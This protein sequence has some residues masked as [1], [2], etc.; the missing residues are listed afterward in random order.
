MSTIKRDIHI[1]SG[2]WVR[3]LDSRIK[4]QTGEY[5]VI[6]RT[7]GYISRS[8]LLMEL[9]LLCG[10]DSFQESELAHV[11]RFCTCE[12]PSSESVYM[13]EVPR[14]FLQK[15]TKKEENLIKAL[16]NL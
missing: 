3:V 9:Q 10:A 13:V 16:K 14:S 5:V 15:L 6:A 2:T 8:T 12:F 11:K 7:D 4:E 1:K